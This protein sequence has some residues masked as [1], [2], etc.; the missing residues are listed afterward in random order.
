MDEL[1]EAFSIERI[2]KSGTKFDINKAK[3]F[4]QQY[5]KAKSDQELA[6][7][8]LI[9]LKAKNIDCSEDKAVKICSLL[10]ERITFPK[11]FIAESQYF[12]ATPEVY[13]EKVVAKKWNDDAIKV[14]S[15]L[16][17][18]FEKLENFESAVIK[19]TMHHTIENLGIKL[20]SV[21]QA[22]RLAITG[23]GA[24]PELTEIM[25]ILGKAEVLHRIDHA[26]AKLGSQVIS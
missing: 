11:E 6:Q 21:M 16:K 18:D 10:K 26:F 25:A 12:F 7:Y 23:V 1:I 9:D 17:E 2:G 20:G 8:L 22:I 14:L 24:G 13:D 19:E 3:W 5:L 15:A 4:N